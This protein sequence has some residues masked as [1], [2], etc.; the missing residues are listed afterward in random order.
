MIYTIFFGLLFGNIVSG[1]ILD[2]F[3]KLREDNESLDYDKSNYC[4][5]CNVSREKL[6][7]DGMKFNEHILE[8]HFLWNY[9]F[10][11]IYL[12]EKNSTDYTG[13]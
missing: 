9:V 2:A 8:K 10:Y 7:K 4:Y 1:I 5:I 13:L 11:I 6:E 3:A 12:R